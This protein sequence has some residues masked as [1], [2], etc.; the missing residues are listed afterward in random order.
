MKLP[1]N[2]LDL[3]SGVGGFAKGFMDAGAKFN[4]HYYSEVARDPIAVYKYKFKDSNYVGDVR[5]VFRRTIK[6][7]I[8]LITF[9]FPC[10]DLS[11]AG[12]GAGLSG[13][14]S[15][16]FF[17]AIRI[18]KEFKP[19]VFVFENVKGLLSS[20]EGKDF[21]IVL[22]TIADIGLYEC[23]WQLVNT[24]WILPQNRERVYFIGHLRGKSRPRVFPFRKGDPEFTQRG[25][26]ATG[27]IASC[28]QSPGHACGNYKGMNMILQKTGGY[29]TRRKVNETGTLQAGGANVMDKVPNVIMSNSKQGRKWE[30]R[31]V[32]PPLRANTGAGHNDVVIRKQPLKFLN[33]NQKN[34][35]GDY[36][37]TI[38]S[39]NT[40]GVYI[41]GNIRRL[42]ERE[43]E[44][45][46]GF[47]TDWTAYGDYDGT[48]KKVSKTQRYKMMGLAVT[49]NW[50]R[51]IM[52]RL[53]L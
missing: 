18:I 12:R 19:E 1:I 15:G 29:T 13:E 37:Y 30:E 34:Y 33:R 53:L 47:E 11:I 36:T 16:L 31:E 38:D 32:L 6:E 2:Y 46:Q 35:D 10:Q 28:L 40:G 8:D 49:T 26:F 41:N 27:E 4:K 17:E 42:T 9:G 24:R 43:C 52:E 3:F 21:E 51:M 25:Q 44:I 23:E 7:K 14:R 50:P 22:R 5:N 48:I 45:L 20:N 39:V